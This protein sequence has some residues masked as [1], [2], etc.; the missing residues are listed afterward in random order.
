MTNKEKLSFDEPKT[1]GIAKFRLFYSI[2]SIIV[3]V[4]IM[5][6][7][8]EPV[9]PICFGLVAMF[10]VYLF[11]PFAYKLIISDQAISSISVL[12]TRTLEWS[13]VAEI[14]NKN[15]NLI[16]INRDGDVKVTVN[17]QID[18]YPD[19]IRSIKQQRPEL[20]K[21]DGIKTFHQNIIQST[22]L[23]IMGLPIIY[24]TIAFS[25]ENGFSLSQDLPSTLFGL[26]IGAILLWQGV[27][28]RE[29]TFDADFL[30]AKYI[31]WEQRFHVND[32]QSASLE[33]RHG[34]NEVSYPV[35]IKLKNGKQLVIEKAKEGNPLLASAVETWMKKYTGKQ[36]D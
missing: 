27:R 12:G 13:E 3:I 34:K 15:G 31:A 16:L 14:K 33:Q 17:Q 20:W 1:Y 28:I 18:G 36:N 6:F 26:F 9:P 23:G 4:G 11:L 5:I 35:H 21:L 19:V 22:L 30:V 7:S 10:A 29:I 24:A 8:K 32:I 2:L 25:L